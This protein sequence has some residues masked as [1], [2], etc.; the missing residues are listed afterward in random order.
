MLKFLPFLRQGVARVAAGVAALTLATLS[1]CG[2]GDGGTPASNAGTL[3]LSLTDAP[4]CGFDKV[5][6]T[7]QKVRI[8]QSSSATDTDAGWTDL[9]LTPRCAWTCSPCATAC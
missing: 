4:A 8:H 3:Q 9:T 2:G 7:L 6:V 5:Y 1:A